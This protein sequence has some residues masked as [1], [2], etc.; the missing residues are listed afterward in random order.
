MDL[1]LQELKVL[2]QSDH[3]NIIK[4]FELAE[5]RKN[6]FIVTEYL[7]GGELY[8]RILKEKQF[9]ERKAAQ[10]LHQ[11]LRGLNYMHKRN[12]AHRDI[13]PE[14][15]LMQ[16]SESLDL[17]IADFGF[18]TAFNQTD[19]LKQKLG[20]P[21]Y[22]APEIVRGDQYTSAVDIWALG[23]IGFIMLSGRPPFKARTQQ[24]IYD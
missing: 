19:K 15:I 2:Q 10:I 17:K 22:M 16:D 23:V 21:L 5:D 9:S 20:S 24:Q 4:V 14:N 1:Q 8:N 13:K 6:F 3:P 18:A 7:K 12:Y 11:V